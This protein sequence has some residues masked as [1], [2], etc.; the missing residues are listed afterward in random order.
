MLAGRNA[1][2][3]GLVLEILMA[4]SW[5]MLPIVLCSAVALAIILERFWS[6]RRKAVVPP[7][8]GEE[9]REWA[10]QRKLDHGAL[11]VEAPSAL[12][13]AERVLAAPRLLVETSESDRCRELARAC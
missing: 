11:C 6:L 7:G 10:R 5:A 13:R 3:G 1:V 8:L 9:V 4:G 2:E 12:V